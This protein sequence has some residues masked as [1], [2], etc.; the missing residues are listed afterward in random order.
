MILIKDI[1]IKIMG[2]KNKY[3]VRFGIFKCGYCNK[4]LEI[5]Y[6]NGIRNKTCGCKRYEL[7]SL[8]NTKHGDSNKNAYYHNLFSLWGGMRDRCNRVSNQDYRYYGGKGNK[9]RPY[10]G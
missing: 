7:T 3:T 10:M 8:N 2:N 6:L 5:R 4:V 1:G 9:N